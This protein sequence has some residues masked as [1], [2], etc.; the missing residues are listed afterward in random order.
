MR[1]TKSEAGSARDSQANRRCLW[2]A[3]LCAATLVLGVGRA[4]PSGA[5]TGC[6]LLGLLSHCTTTTTAP[7]HGS[8]VVV[9]LPPVGNVTVT[10]PTIPPL[11]VLSG[12]P[13]ADPHAAA[14]RLLEL[15]NHERSAAGL[16]TLSMRDDV[17]A[18]AQ[19]QSAAMAAKNAVWH[20][21][22]LFSSTVRSALGASAL[23]ENVGG[24]T[25]V[26]GIHARFMAS[27]HHRDNILDPRFNVAG[28]AVVAAGSGE[29]YVTEDF[30]QAVGAPHPAPHPPAPAAPRPAGPPPASVATA[31][32]VPV[33]V[34]LPTAA[35][36]VAVAPAAAGDALPAP[37][38][39]A[40][41]SGPLARASTS[42]STTTAAAAA[43]LILLAVTGATGLAWARR[44]D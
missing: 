23:G 44:Q 26:D 13:P 20:N 21:D 8:G 31:M 16:G 3:A 9:P 27:Q 34:A 28:F 30:V 32:A 22:N 40:G 6:G 25:S 2:A 10:I 15:V 12:P 5:A 39:A 29:L 14:L 43:G 1:G 38:A 7:A 19:G 18:I 4:A 17:V 41:M 37:L 35:V 33:A 11:P 24:D 42:T 36:P